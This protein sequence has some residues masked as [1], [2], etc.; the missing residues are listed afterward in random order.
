MM[1]VCSGLVSCAVGRLCRRGCLKMS[2]F[3][4]MIYKLPFWIIF[5]KIFKLSLWI[6]YCCKFSCSKSFVCKLIV[7]IIF[8]VKYAN[9][10]SKSC[11]PSNENYCFGSS[12]DLSPSHLKWRAWAVLGMWRGKPGRCCHHTAGWLRH[13][14]K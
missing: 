6:L 13:P 7:L 5:G 1:P 2:F 14:N 3:L 10:R 12:C 8:V 9:L 4:Y 11:F